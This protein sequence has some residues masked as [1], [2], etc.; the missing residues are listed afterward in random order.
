MVEEWTVGNGPKAAMDGRKIE[1]NRSVD[2]WIG[3][4]LPKM[5]KK[6]IILARMEDG[7]IQ[8]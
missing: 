8:Q 6:Q 3:M 1:G 4:E 7:T 5:G 2:R